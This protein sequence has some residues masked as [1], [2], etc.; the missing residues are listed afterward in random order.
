[1]VQNV[2][3]VLFL[4]SG[5][6]LVVA[7][8]GTFQPQQPHASVIETPAAVPPAPFSAAPQ[9]LAAASPLEHR[10][11]LLGVV[12]PTAAQDGQEW[13]EGSLED[14]DPDYTPSR[15]EG[16]GSTESDTQ[17]YEAVDEGVWQYFLGSVGLPC[18]LQP[19]CMPH[20]LVRKPDSPIHMPFN[21]NTLQ[22]LVIYMN[23]IYDFQTVSSL[24][25]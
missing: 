5:G 24:I 7:N 17:E 3:Q 20:A 16:E 18:I 14:S 25:S 1:M 15:A 22:N 12:Q 10:S 8:I 21:S 9:P 11:V 4:M 6:Q 23:V 19:P 13:G 2:P